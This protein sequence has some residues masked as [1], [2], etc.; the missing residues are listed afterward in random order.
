MVSRDYNAKAG[1]ARSA[2]ASDQVVADWQ[3]ETVEL[4]ADLLFATKLMMDVCA[5]GK[6]SKIAVEN[7]KDFTEDDAKILTLPAHQTAFNA[8]WRF[9]CNHGEHCGFNSR[10]DYVAGKMIVTPWLRDWTAMVRSSLA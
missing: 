1:A 3:S 4:P 9:H 6:A 5:K 7:T 2:Y 8:D 10:F